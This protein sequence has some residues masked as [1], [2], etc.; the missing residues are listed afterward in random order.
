MKTG[1]FNMLVNTTIVTVANALLPA[2]VTSV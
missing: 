2:V 1:S